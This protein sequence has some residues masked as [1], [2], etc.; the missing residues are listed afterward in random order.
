M[1]SSGFLNQ[2]ST[3]RKVRNPQNTAAV[4]AYL[5]LLDR[6]G[7][8]QQAI[9]E[10]AT[11]VPADCPLS[12]YAPTLLHLAQVSG[13]WQRYLEICQQREDV[14][15]FAAGQLSRQSV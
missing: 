8:A 2:M 3:A 9:D 7:R 11:L 12:P 6:T 1:M 4:E 5:V 14:V 15:G 10:Y 13:G